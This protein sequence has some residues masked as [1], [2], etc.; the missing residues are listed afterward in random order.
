[1]WR[2]INSIAI[3]YFFS[4]AKSCLSKI[5]KTPAH[6]CAGVFGW[7]IVG[8]ESHPITTACEVD[9][10]DVIEEVRAV[11]LARDHHNGITTVFK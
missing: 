3:Q 4:S 8:L 5:I 6:L 11:F 9:T 7:S 2:S 10:L 1:M